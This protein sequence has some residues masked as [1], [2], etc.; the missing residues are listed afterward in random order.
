[1]HAIAGEGIS[2]QTIEAMQPED[3]ANLAQRLETDD[4]SNPFEALNDWHLL[5][6]IALHN[7]DLVEPYRYLLDFETYDES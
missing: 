5:R 3:V 6:A 1:M 2:A 7:W 4:Y